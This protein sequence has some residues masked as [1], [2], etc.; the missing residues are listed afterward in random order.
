[1]P[2]LRA[3]ADAERLAAELTFAGGRLEELT[4]DPP[5]LYGE[6]A[7][8]TDSEQALWSILILVYL[9]PLEDAGDPFEA[10]RGALTPWAGGEL[11][12]PDR[13]ARGPRSPHE[14]G[15]G[16]RALAAYR[17]WA[18][19]A[20]SQQRAFAGDHSWTASRRFG[21]LHERLALP[22]FGRA[23]RFELLTVLGRLGLFELEADGLHF[24]DGDPSTLAAK[25]V[26]GIADPLLLER[27]ASELASAV[28]LPLDALDLAL[29]NWQADR[30][31]TLGARVTTG[32]EPALSTVRAALGL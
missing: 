5:G 16:T 7:G 15:A 13:L 10:I 8:E 29:Y 18:S 24:R 9:S 4:L 6:L 21:R 28:A 32:G 2:G 17:G 11:P 26:F 31:A 14:P 20:G 23:G 22:G 1:V 25:R 12:D 27:R 3:S 19:R 30:R